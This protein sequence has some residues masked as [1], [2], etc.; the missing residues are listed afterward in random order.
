MKSKILIVEDNKD[1]LF[2]LD[3]ILKANDYDPILAKNGKEALD[4]LVELDKA[5]DLIIS[6]ILMP[7]MNGYQFFKKVSDNPRW[8]RIPFI[9]LT[10]R[11]KPEDIRMGKLLG[12]DDYI[13]KPFDEKDLLASINGRLERNRRILAIEK[14]FTLTPKTK[15]ITPDIKSKEDEIRLLLVFWDDKQGPYLKDYYPK[16]ELNKISLNNISNQLFSAAISIYGQ[17]EMTKAE[18]ALLRVANFKTDAYL[19]FDAYKEEKERFGEK[20]FMLAVIASKISYFHSFEIKQVLSN[21]SEKIKNKEKANLDRY[22]KEI[23]DILIK[24]VNLYE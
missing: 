17:D 22:W 8:N 6:D 12:A 7:Q 15:I 24:S 14:E 11:A 23:L 18:G 21:L 5:P 20:Q 19:Y 9:F 1:L 2:N 3:L 4:K 13:T 16:K 10:A